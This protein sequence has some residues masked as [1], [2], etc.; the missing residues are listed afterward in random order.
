MTEQFLT[1]FCSRVLHSLQY[2]YFSASHNAVDKNDVNFGRLR[3]RR[4][5][6]GMQNNAFL[7]YYILFK[8]L[9]CVPACSALSHLCSSVSCCTV[10]LGGEICIFAIFRHQDQV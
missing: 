5:V 6:V 2:L 8:M 1:P 9:R 7:N 4:P 3:D 10:M